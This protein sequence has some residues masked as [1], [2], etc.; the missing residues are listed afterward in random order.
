MKLET[1]EYGRRR[2]REMLLYERVDYDEACDIRRS[3]IAPVIPEARM[4]LYKCSH[5]QAQSADRFFHYRGKWSSSVCY[6]CYLKYKWR[7]V[8]P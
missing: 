3:F 2:F 5:C 1:Y 7:K 4:S 6:D 8:K